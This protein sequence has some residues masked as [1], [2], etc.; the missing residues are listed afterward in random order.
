MTGASQ[1]TFTVRLES[2]GGVALEQAG[3]GFSKSVPPEV[4]SRSSLLTEVVDL[5]DEKGVL[6]APS[7][8]VGAWLQFAEESYAALA[9]KSASPC[10]SWCARYLLLKAVRRF[11]FPRLFKETA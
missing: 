7:G 2:G 6:V 10:P 4:V 9:G 3:G 5:R 11:L 1:V 8:F